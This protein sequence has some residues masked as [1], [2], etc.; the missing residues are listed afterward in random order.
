[1]CSLPELLRRFWQGEG[2][3]NKLAGKSYLFLQKKI[4]SFKGIIGITFVS[5]FYS[6]DLEVSE[7]IA[8]AKVVCVMNYLS[9][10]SSSEISTR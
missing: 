3:T 10:I 1:M 6:G 8:G 2:Q 9:C 4:A 5:L 7:S